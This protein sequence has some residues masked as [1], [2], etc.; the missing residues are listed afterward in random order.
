LDEA[1]AVRGMVAVVVVATSLALLGA[2]AGAAGAADECRGLKT[3]IPVA[4]PWVVVP[5]GGVEYELGCPRTA[6]IVAGT[7]AR[8]S[9]AD[10][11]VSF[12]GE[13]GSPVAPGVTTRSSV[14]F[15]ATTTRPGAV[16]TSFKPY[17]GC[18][19]TRGGGG[20]ALT[21]VAAAPGL[22]PAQ[23][24]TSV[25]VSRR[26]RTSPLT[27]GVAC[28]RGARLVDS[29]YAVAFRRAEPPSPVLVGGV[30]ATPRAGGNGIAVRTTTAVSARIAGAEIQVR[31]VCVR[32]R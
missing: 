26:L 27:V 8:L 28:P 21:G 17:I 22:R 29:S 12:R 32:A 3:C 10:V 5:V 25:T 13:L 7:D 9:S 2:T 6:G 18:L 11:D 20:R 16:A 1:A 30:S 14:V 15:R 19:P 24:T 31:V 4:G 23:Q